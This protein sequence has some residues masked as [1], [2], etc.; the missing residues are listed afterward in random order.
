MA[1]PSPTTQNPHHPRS[2]IALF[3]SVNPSPPVLLP[4]EAVSLPSTHLTPHIPLPTSH[5]TPHPT[6]HFSLHPTPTPLHRNSFIPHPAHPSPLYCRSLLLTSVHLPYM[7]ICTHFHTP[8]HTPTLHTPFQ[9]AIHII[10]TTSK[11]NFSI[12]EA[13]P[14]SPSAP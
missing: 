4:A 9:I 10:I 6:S 12:L 14:D 5:Y 8:I 3:L 1:K 11:Y 2:L 13:P 7:Y